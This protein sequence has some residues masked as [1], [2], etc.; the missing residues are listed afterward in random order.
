MQ[1]IAVI[2]CAGSGKSTFA[3]RLGE[4]L[5]VSVTHLDALYWRPG[6]AETPKDEWRETVARLVADERWLID[7]NYGGT[8]D[9]RL[10]T[11]DTVIYLDLPRRVCLWRVVKRWAMY[12]RR[13]RPDMAEGCRERLDPRFLKWIWQYPGNSRPKTVAALASNARDSLDVY[14]LR[15][16]ADIDEFL[17]IATPAAPA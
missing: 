1:R 15:S 5:G 8:L 14:V 4:R 2:G 3:R 13:S 17:A 10:E 16:T 12:G 11:A 6:W 7:G 9:L